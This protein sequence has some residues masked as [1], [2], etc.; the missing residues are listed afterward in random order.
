[1]KIV[2]LLLDGTVPSRID[3]RA[4]LDTVFTFVIPDGRIARM[5]AIRNPHNLKRLDRVAE[6]R[7]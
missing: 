1:V 7:R 3:P 2:Q 5:Y 4:E 6:L